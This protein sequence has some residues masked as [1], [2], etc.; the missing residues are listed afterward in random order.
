[1]NERIKKRRLEL[2][3]TMLEVANHVGVSE[4]TVSRW[5]SGYIANMRQDRILLLA[6]ILKVEP[7]YLIGWEK[8]ETPEPP[9]P[10]LSDVY[11]RLAK[12]A[13]ERKIRPEEIREALDLID[14]LR[15]RD[16][17]K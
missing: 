14:M 7:G 6:E 9:P 1:M 4:A 17:K 12:E 2:N 5:E 15:R 13:E 11:F 3:L 10:Q 16:R 8:S